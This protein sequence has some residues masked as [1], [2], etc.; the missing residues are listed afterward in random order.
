[1]ERRALR[2]G[3]IA[4]LAAAAVIALLR[5]RLWSHGVP[6]V[7]GHGLGNAF[8]GLDLERSQAYRS[9]RWGFVVA[10]AVLG[11]A[12]AVAVA[13]SGRLWQPW[14][15]RR[16]GNRRW[17]AGAIFGAGLAV[18]TA[19]VLLPVRIGAYAVGRDFGI[20]V[21]PV[22]AWLVDVGTATVIGMLLFGAVGL[23]TAVLIGRSPT[24]WWVGLGAVAVV[25]TFVM[26]ALAP[27]VIEPAFQHTKPLDDP[28][29]EAAILRVAAREGVDAR[30][31]EIADASRRT[32]AVNAYVSGIGP[33]R[34][35][36]LYDTLVD[37]LPRD[38]VV[39]VAA[40]E[41]AHVEH[42][43]VVKGTTWAAALMLPAC[44]LVFA[45]VGWRTGWSPAAPGRDGTDL[46]LRRT[47]V[48]GA[49]IVVLAALSSPL[50]N[51]VSRA[52]E[53]EADWTA[54]TATADAG[55]QERL[56]ESLAQRSLATP[57]TPAVLQW[58]FGTH[59]QPVDRL[60]MA[61]H[62]ADVEGH[63]R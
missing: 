61:R 41:L 44:L 56:I 4:L 53:R 24:R 34:R 35:I 17:L 33:S 42:A 25:A 48:A 55:A 54:L 36:V 63:A 10:G 7:D 60:A 13:V 3:G 21:Q 26:S 28:A 23:I 12:V 43:H 29:L 47:A 45:V 52:Y 2:I 20:I 8:P 16:C 49:A 19:L 22:G 38:E 39:A 46:V 62:Y 27:V 1:M 9:A 18:V 59:P 14:L 57:R 30:G 50:A 15:A 58:W 31:V 37:G 6:G 11:P 40:H 5:W 32:T 51:W